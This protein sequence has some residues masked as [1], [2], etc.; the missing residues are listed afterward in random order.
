MN[1]RGLPHGFTF[2]EL[3]VALAI[4]CILAVA[5]VP[6]IRQLLL[7]N[8]LRAAAEI[9]AQFIQTARSEAIQRQQNAYLVL[10][11]GNPWCYGVNPGSTCSC[12]PS[13]TCSLGSISSTDY[14]GITTLVN[15]GFTSNY[16]YFDSVRGLPN[17]TSTVSFS[18]SDKLIKVKISQL[19]NITMC[20]TNVT[21]YQAC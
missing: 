15:T 6:I 18:T 11:S 8:R 16:V 5:T 1:N 3:T 17:E 12:S 9:F 14:T 7:E 10:Q 20:S 21:G 2:L 19:G 4:T 13:N